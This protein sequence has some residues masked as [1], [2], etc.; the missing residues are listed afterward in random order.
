MRIEI[1]KD[2]VIRTIPNNFVLCKSTGSKVTD[3]ET[4]KSVEGY[5]DETFHGSFEDALR[6]MCK[7]EIHA[8]RATTVVGLQKEYC[9]LSKLIDKFSEQLGERKII[10]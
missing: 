1:Y 6:S 10:K 3:E 2:W 8:S 9:K 4:G 7:K 5:K